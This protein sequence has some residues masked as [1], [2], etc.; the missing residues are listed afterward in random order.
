MAGQMSNFQKFYDFSTLR[1][2]IFKTIKTIDRSGMGPSPACSPFNSAQNEEFL[3][4]SV[5]YLGR[6]QGAS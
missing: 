6:I 4:I 3:C 5:E 1:V 2:R